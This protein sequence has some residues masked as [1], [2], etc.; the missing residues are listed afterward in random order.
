MAGTYI[1]TVTVASGCTS[2]L[3]VTAVVNAPSATFTATSSVAV[4][5]NAS[6]TYTGT[7]PSTSTYSWNFN[8]G[9]PATGT[10]QGPF[11][12]Q[13]ATCLVLKK[14]YTFND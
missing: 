1:C 10:G 12:V 2:Q 11:S 3:I 13:W 8:G 6:I 9:T 14:V 4:G 7:D 5:S